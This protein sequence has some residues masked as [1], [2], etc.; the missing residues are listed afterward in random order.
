MA[1]DDKTVWV[2]HEGSNDVGAVDL[3]SGKTTTIAVGNAPR[4]I[5]VQPAATKS[6]AAG[7]PTVSI[8]NFAFAPSPVKVERGSAVTWINAD[9]APHALAFGDGTTPSDLLLPRQRFTRHYASAGTFDHVFSAHPS[10]AAR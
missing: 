8:A 7:P 5:V 4:K 10:C 1:S 2:T 9:G 6:A 3:A